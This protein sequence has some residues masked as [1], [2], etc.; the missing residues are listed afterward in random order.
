MCLL[1]G[2]SMP[3]VTCP[4]KPE[5]ASRTMRHQTCRACLN[6]PYPFSPQHDISRPA[7][8]A[9][10]R[11]TEP[12]P[13]LPKLTLPLP[14]CHTTPCL[15]FPHSDITQLSVPELACLN[16]PSIAIPRLVGHCH[17]LPAKTHLTLSCLN[18]QN[19]TRLVIPATPSLTRPYRTS[20]ELTSPYINRPFR[21]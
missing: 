8:P 2:N 5:R 17:T 19:A 18:L 7:S 16:T 1:S 13:T 20:P 12:Q 3:A 15:A 9:V 10:Q 6:V 14:T 21:S 11:H 4:T